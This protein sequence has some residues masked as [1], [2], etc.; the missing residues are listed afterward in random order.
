MIS[1]IMQLF[2]GFLIFGTIA[3]IALVWAL[4]HTA[5]GREDETG[6]HPDKTARS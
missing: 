3:L 2:V 1:L 6:F 4:R 5:D